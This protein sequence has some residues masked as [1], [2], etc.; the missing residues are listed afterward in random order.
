MEA[1][2]QLLTASELAKVLNLPVS[3]VWRLSRDG[4]LPCLRI[5]GGRRQLRFSLP[6]V[7]EALEAGEKV[8]GQSV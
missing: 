3:Q 7:L 5:P 1:D 6:R 2:T 4:R 8:T